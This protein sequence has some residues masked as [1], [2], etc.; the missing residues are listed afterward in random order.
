MS[1]H[2]PEAAERIAR[3]SVVGRLRVHEYQ[4]ALERGTQEQIEDGRRKLEALDIDP[5]EA[6][7]LPVGRPDLEGDR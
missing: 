1:A 2:D 4:R 7:W 3:L 6:A 5:Y